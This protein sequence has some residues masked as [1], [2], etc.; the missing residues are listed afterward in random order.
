MPKEKSCRQGFTL[1]E[2]SI[3]LVVIGLII[4][5]ILVGQDLIKAAAVRSQISQIE[6]YNTAVHA[7]QNKY[8]YLPGD[9]IAAYASQFGLVT[10]CTF[11]SSGNE[12]DG[13][14]NGII[15]GNG[16]TWNNCGLGHGGCCIQ[17]GETMMFWGDLALA[18][19]IEGHY[20][21]TDG[22][23][24]FNNGSNGYS[25]PNGL[26]PP[27]SIG[28]TNSVYVYSDG[29]SSGHPGSNNYFGI[30]VVTT[31]N[32]GG[33]NAFGTQVGLTVSQA[34]NIDKKM[35]DGSPE[36]GKVIAQFVNGN[37]TASHYWVQG[38]GG[39][40]DTTTAI[41]PSTITCYDNEGNGTNAK[42]YSMS[43]A[44]GSGVNCALSFQ[45]Q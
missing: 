10:R 8:G 27:A 32:S 42:A 3:V 39:P 23:S 44:N 38:D 40:T 6:K 13:D 15:E 29:S 34:Y 43:A 1:I 4:G 22:Q 35:D 33:N 12:G 28:A 2:M 24:Q 19:L 17:M 5:G 20:E 31:G 16:N 21:T 11:G 18:G 14:G 26:L 36:S 30:S 41:T 37:V 7:F 25:S 9:M 45:F